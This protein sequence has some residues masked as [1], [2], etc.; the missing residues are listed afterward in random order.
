MGNTSSVISNEII[1][2]A[3]RLMNNDV[4][5]IESVINVDR[6]LW[7]FAVTTVLSNEDTY[8]TTIIHN[9]YMYQTADGKFQMIPWDLTESFC[10]ILFTGGTPHLLHL[11]LAVGKRL[12]A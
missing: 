10:G 5:N 3:S 11:L 4:A 2:K 7:N 12:W 6:V 9:Y 8:N 1:E